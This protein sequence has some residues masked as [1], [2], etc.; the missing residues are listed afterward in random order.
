MILYGLYSLCRKV[1]SVGV[2]EPHPIVREVAED[3]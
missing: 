1:A 3:Y 2:M